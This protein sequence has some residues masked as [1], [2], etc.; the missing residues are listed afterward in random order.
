[1]KIKLQ[2]K[3]IECAILVFIF[4]YISQLAHA[5]CYQDLY[6]HWLSD[7]GIFVKM[8]NP[9]STKKIGGSNKIGNKSISYQGSFFFE[10]KILTVFPHTVESVEK[11]YETKF[12]DNTLKFKVFFS[13]NRQYLVLHP[14]SEEAQKYFGTAHLTLFNE[15]FVKFENL[16]IDSIS[17]TRRALPFTL[18]INKVGDLT[19]VWRVPQRREKYKRYKASLTETEFA[20]LKKLVAHSQITTMSRCKMNR[21]CIDCY[22]LNLKVFHNGQVSH[23]RAGFVHET[24]KPLLQYFSRIYFEKKWKKIKRRKKGLFKK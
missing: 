4:S 7:D 5:Q 22:S 8:N 21:Q 13:A 24:V 19:L 16:T 9:A 1:M 10:E 12:P 17:Y 11:N 20:E 18:G 2:F 6:G 14:L 23:Y 3:S 15:H